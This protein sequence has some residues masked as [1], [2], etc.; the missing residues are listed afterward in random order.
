MCSFVAFLGGRGD[1]T[2][3][4]PPVLALRE[5]PTAGAPRETDEGS[6][7]EY[8]TQKYHDFQ[9]VWEFVRQHQEEVA[10]RMK[11]R[12]DRYCRNYH[13]QLGDLVLV[14]HWLHPGLRASRKQVERFYGPYLVH[15]LRGPNAVVL[16][17]MPPRVPNVM[18]VSFI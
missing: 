4:T 14:S 7:N 13:C 16:Q 5:D 18:N 11:A 3:P 8:V 10:A 2:D 12:E 9:N 6:R 17:E 15:E 1:V